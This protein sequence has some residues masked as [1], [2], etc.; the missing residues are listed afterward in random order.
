MHRSAYGVQLQLMM[1]VFESKQGFIILSVA[2]EILDKQL[3]NER[4]LCSK[5][6]TIPLIVIIIIVIIIIVI[7]IIL[8]HVGSSYLFNLS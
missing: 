4:H 1:A 3:S 5:T 6:I 8:H 7:I 2:A